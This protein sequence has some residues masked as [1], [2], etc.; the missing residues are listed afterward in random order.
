MSLSF[1]FPHNIKSALSLYV[2]FCKVQYNAGEASYQL[3]SPAVAGV[4]CFQ[5]GHSLSEKAVFSNI[6]NIQSHISF[7]NGHSAAYH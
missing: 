6:T 5:P 4:G 7:D 2:E 3:P 1:F